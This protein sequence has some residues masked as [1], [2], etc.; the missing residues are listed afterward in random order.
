MAA[1]IS[2][3][4][5]HYTNNERNTKKWQPRFIVIQYHKHNCSMIQTHNPHVKDKLAKNDNA[6]SLRCVQDYVVVTCCK[7]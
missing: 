1:H 4:V 6:M 2:D 7:D 3:F 5:F